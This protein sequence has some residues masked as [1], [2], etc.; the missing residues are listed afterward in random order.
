MMKKSKKTSDQD[1][2][3]AY[4]KMINS[5]QKTSKKILEDITKNA[6]GNNVLSTKRI[7]AG[8]VNEVYRV[9]TDNKG[10]FIVR[11]SL[12]KDNNFLQ[13]KWAIAQAREVGV[14]APEIVSIG[15]KNINGSIIKFCV[16]KYIDGDVLEMG[17]IDFDSLT[18]IEKKEYLYQA[19]DTL[20]KIHSIKTNGIGK[21]NSFGVSQQD[22]LNDFFKIWESDKLRKKFAQLIEY[23][24]KTAERIAKSLISYKPLYNKIEPRLNHGDFFLRHL[25]VR[26]KKITG[27]LDWGEVRSD[28]PVYDFANWSFWI[29]NPKYMNWLKEGYLN[30]FLFDDSFEGF[31]HLIK[32]MI[33]TEVLNWYQSQNRIRLVERAK[34]KII[35]ELD[36]FKND[37]K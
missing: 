20:S 10:I 13:E 33:G 12:D 2:Y 32:L 9:V 15:E 37:K 23:N 6:T 14:L 22:T 1:E 7:I 28:S 35:K 16:N 11:I 27:V 29:D 30:K 3:K 26:N 25:A 36:Y 17:P 18:E 24:S 4:L 19:G 34:V 5:R 21:I 31:L 8:E